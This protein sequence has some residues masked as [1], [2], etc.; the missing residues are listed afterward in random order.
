MTKGGRKRD[1]YGV[2]K[3]KDQEDQVEKERKKGGKEGDIVKTKG[4]FRGHVETQYN[5]SFFSPN[6]K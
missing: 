6:K 1:S 5:R 4:N 3:G 2:G